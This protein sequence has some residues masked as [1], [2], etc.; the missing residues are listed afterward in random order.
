MS[1]L[2]KRALAAKTGQKPFPELQR[3]FLER[4]RSDFGIEA[5]VMDVDTRRLRPM[6]RQ[7]LEIGLPRMR[8]LERHRES[9][10]RQAIL[11]LF[12]ELFR[13]IPDPTLPPLEELTALQ[14]GFY[15]I[16]EEAADFA[17]WRLE[18]EGLDIPKALEA[19]FKAEGLS[20]VDDLT[21]LHLVIRWDTPE[22]AKANAASGLN[23]KVVEE[24][25]KLLRSHEPGGWITADAVHLEFIS[26]DEATPDYYR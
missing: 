7:I 10:H 9:P 18:N 3:R 25:L 22:R 8:D 20:G 2:Y 11:K 17:V 6:G 16:E 24:V 26:N 13:E 15:S 12:L 19:A 4:L 14:T 23:A 5:L 1:S 21:D